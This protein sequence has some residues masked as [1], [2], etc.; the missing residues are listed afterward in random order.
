M[1]RRGR[2]RPGSYLPSQQ[3]NAVD[4]H[5]DGCAR[6]CQFLLFCAISAAVAMG[7][8]AV[9]SCEFLIYLKPLDQQVDSSST[10]TTYTGNTGRNGTL[11]WVLQVNN[12]TNATGG[13]PN[14]PTGSLEADQ[15]GLGIWRYKYHI[16]DEICYWYDEDD[17]RDKS[18]ELRVA[19]WG[20]SLSL[21]FSGLA[22]FFLMV[23]FCCCRFPCSRVIA[24]LCFALAAASL[25]GCFLA[26]SHNECK[27][28]SNNAYACDIGTGAI[29]MVIMFFLLLLCLC[30]SCMTP[31]STPLCKVVQQREQ[32]SE[33]DPCICGC[34]KGCSKRTK[35]DIYEDNPEL[36]LAELPSETV[37][38]PAGDR[39]GTHTYKHYYDDQ[40]GG[41]T[42]QSQYAA[43]TQR[44]LTCERDYQ[45]MLDRFKNECT[46]LQ[47]DSALFTQRKQ[48][49]DDSGIAKKLDDYY[50]DEEDMDKFRASEMQQN[51][52]WRYIL[53]LP[54][55]EIVDPE[56]ARLALVLSS[57]R[58][59]SRQAKSIMERI[60]QD[61]EE[62]IKSPEE[63]VNAAL[64]EI[65]M[66]K[67]QRAHEK[68]KKS[69][70]VEAQ[71]DGDGSHDVASV[72]EKHAN[73][74]TPLED[75]SHLNGGNDVRGSRSNHVSEPLLLTTAVMSDDEMMD[76]IE[77]RV[78]LPTS[79]P[80][81][82]VFVSTITP[83][84]PSEEIVFEEPELAFMDAEQMVDQ[85]PH[86]WIPF[87]WGD[88]RDEADKKYS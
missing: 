70:N 86:S 21:G 87:G 42:L 17:P 31:K 67:S 55:N 9:F 57:M 53:T 15:A 60:E 6:F 12:R 78:K 20:S 64:M 40:L 68:A 82:D 88:S 84:S 23:E 43:A 52:D 83:R 76:Q 35:E 3:F 75:D 16:E 26:F 10:A 13:T 50:D 66:K 51:A 34:C 29:Y 74:T 18:L 85:K 80:S 65:E 48:K 36:L 62:H 41:I 7:V 63:K 81:S 58:E 19:Q 14:S 61:L 4:E 37:E 27:L 56:L 71:Q 59:N 44:W 46:E 45:T 25:P 5:T 39:A 49:L 11:A 32:E 24:H 79:G 8:L 73:T 22:M 2:S 69:N 47:Q 72:T 28:F 77:A 30:L 54:P 38:V 1:P 33:Q